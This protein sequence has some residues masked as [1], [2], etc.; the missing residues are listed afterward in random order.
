MEEISAD[1][2]LDMEIENV[3]NKNV[4]YYTDRMSIDDIFDIYRK[5]RRAIL[6]VIQNNPTELQNYLSGTKS[7]ISRDD[8][9]PSLI[10]NPNEP[11]PH[12]KINRQCYHCRIL[13]RL[14]NGSDEIYGNG[15]SI[16]LEHGIEKG[17]KL[18]IYKCPNPN[19]S[20]KVNYLSSMLLKKML[21]IE[22]DLLTCEPI[23]SNM[24]DLT[25]IGTDF[26]TNG[27]L[28]SLLLDQIFDQYER[29]YTSRIYTTFFCRDKA[30]VMKKDESVNT[31]IDLDL[32]NFD[33]KIFLTSLSESLNILK[34]Y[35][36]TFGNP[37]IDI[38]G[39]TSNGQLRFL[40]LSGSGIT[41]DKKTRLYYHTHDIN[42]C[43]DRI[44]SPMFEIINQKKKDG[45]IDVWYRFPSGDKLL[46][47]LKLS[48]AGVPMFPSSLD[49]YSF[50]ISLMSHENCRS[51]I[52][53]NPKLIS[54]WESLWCYSD[55]EKVN[56]RIAKE[57]LI[58][59]VSKISNIIH[60]IKLRCNANN[61]ILES[62]LR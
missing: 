56:R 41:I 15:I 10:F 28:V 19:I 5:E 4:L 22:T 24:T 29:S 47:Y 42:F 11:N 33:M 36:F 60:G 17:N 34:N 40:K 25:Y 2:N 21:R 58:T 49:I 46:T 43:F 53:E 27:L 62:L 38:L 12:L 51:K 14:Y 37:T 6:K 54:I 3:A 48:H 8:S 61:F 50:W 59:D 20:V 26:F 13:S 57:G 32:S 31:I 18:K 16:I 30:Y 39:L 7:L 35:E 9:C 55:L 52:V 45:T 1:T 23:L 44:I